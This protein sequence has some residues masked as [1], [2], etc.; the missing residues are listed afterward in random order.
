MTIIEFRKLIPENYPTDMAG[1]LI[2]DVQAGR[3]DAEKA[4]SYA[5]IIHQF[6]ESPKGNKANA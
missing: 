5:W 3:Y 4:I 6:R 1:F 2:A